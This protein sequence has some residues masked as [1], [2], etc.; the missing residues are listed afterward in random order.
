[1]SKFLSTLFS[2]ALVVSIVAVIV[3]L[4][5]KNIDDGGAFA[6]ILGR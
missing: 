2:V 5:I 3:M 6:Y 4:V 1:M